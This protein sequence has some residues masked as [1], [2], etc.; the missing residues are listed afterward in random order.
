MVTPQALQENVVGLFSRDAL[1][2]ITLPHTRQSRCPSSRAS[3]STITER[4]LRVVKRTFCIKLIT[5]QKGPALIS[6]E[7]SDDERGECR[8]ARRFGFAQQ[9]ELPIPM[10]EMKE[11]AN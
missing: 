6:K 7:A 9:L 10:P 11:T 3:M 4:T 1:G 2:D 5:F 8:I